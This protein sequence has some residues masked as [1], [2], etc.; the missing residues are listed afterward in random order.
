MVVQN[1]LVFANIEYQLACPLLVDENLA[2]NVSDLLALFVNERLDLVQC[3]LVRLQECLTVTERF[4]CEII[5][6]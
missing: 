5:K 4:A 1:G 3:A 2:L 6:N